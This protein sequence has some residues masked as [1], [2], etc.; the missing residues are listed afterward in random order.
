MIGNTTVQIASFNESS[1]HNHVLF[2]CKNMLYRPRRRKWLY[3]GA[4]TRV[5]RPQSPAFCGFRVRR[6]PTPRFM[7]T[8]QHP[9]FWYPVRQD[10]SNMY[11]PCGRSQLVITA[12]CALP[13]LPTTSRDSAS[14]AAS[15]RRPRTQ[16]REVEV[17]TSCQ[18][19]RIEATLPGSLG[20][21]RCRSRARRPR[22]GVARRGPFPTHR[23]VCQMLQTSPSVL[24]VCGQV[25]RPY[26][27]DWYL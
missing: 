23:Q 25:R 2:V 13:F 11:I 5:R 21:G 7:P 22:R 26:L 9:F 17:T 4:M 12:S 1:E 27:T 10:L 6:R 20:F 8:L 19:R 15:R 18:S 16:T 14:A 3:H 24:F